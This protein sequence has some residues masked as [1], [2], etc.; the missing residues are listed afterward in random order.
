MASD[1]NGNIVVGIDGSPGSAHALRWAI[2]W[3]RRRGGGR[4]QAVMAWHYPAL[5]LLPSPFGQGVPPADAMTDAT[6][7]AMAT[8]ID[9]IVAETG[10]EV[11][12]MVVEGA[13]APVLTEAAE[14]A[15][16]LVLGSRGLGR[17]AAVLRGSVSRRVVAS[18][19]CPVAVV[20]DDAPVEAQGPIVVGVDGSPNSLDALRWAAS[21]GDGPIHAILA[22]EFPLGPEY[23]LPGVSV[24]DPQAVAQKVV[25]QSVADALGD[26]A[27]VTCTAVVGDPREVLTTAVPGASL[28]V[29]G[30]R[31]A[32]GIPGLVAGSVTTSIVAHA[33]LPVVVVP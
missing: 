20:P 3:S 19:P 29:V 1:A 16:L 5:L 17:A 23:E 28:I 12:Q 27:D 6:R 32:T 25:E 33:P 24:D 9:P 4:V 8:V 22:Y 26:R 10:V 31:G 18:A 7:T 21:A 11:E 13:A 30:A 2:A 15:R 14:S